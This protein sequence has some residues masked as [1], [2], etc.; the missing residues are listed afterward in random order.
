MSFQAR[1]MDISE[2]EKFNKFIESSPKGHVLQTWEWG[3]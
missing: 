1:L 2:K 3:I